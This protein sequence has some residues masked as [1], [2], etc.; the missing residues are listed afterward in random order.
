M[1]NALFDWVWMRFCESHIASA[2]CK[3]NETQNRVSAF[4]FYFHSCV[5]DF[6]KIVHLFDSAKCILDADAAQN[7][8]PRVQST[9]VTC[10]ERRNGKNESHIAPSLVKFHWT[11]TFRFPSDVDSADNGHQQRNDKH[12]PQNMTACIN[13]FRLAFAWKTAFDV[14]IGFTLLERR[15]IVCV[16][17]TNIAQAHTQP[18]ATRTSELMDVREPIAS[19][20]CLCTKETHLFIHVWVRITNFV[21]RNV[22]TRRSSS[23]SRSRIQ[24]VSSHTNARKHAHTNLEFMAFLTFIIIVTLK[25]W[26]KLI[27]SDLNFA[28]I[29]SA[30]SSLIEWPQQQKIVH[31]FHFAVRHWSHRQ[32]THASRPLFRVNAAYDRRPWQLHGDG[33][34]ARNEFTKWTTHLNYLHQDWQS[35]PKNLPSSLSYTKRFTWN[36]GGFLRSKKPASMCCRGSGNCDL[37]FDIVC[38][39]LC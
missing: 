2:P 16:E 19:L 3:V 8:L 10:N 12:A 32:N 20:F 5:F 11:T 38:L 23:R 29:S 33:R 18:S 22:L 4:Y 7:T 31:K 21:E 24:S 1:N 34:R 26:A 39:F 9:H 35:R 36:G 37:L 28:H 14:D 30:V 6:M 27:V 17:K 15:V 13:I 25:K